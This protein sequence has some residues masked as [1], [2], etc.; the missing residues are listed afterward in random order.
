MKK[1]KVLRGMLITLLVLAILVS[2]GYLYTQF[3]GAILLP[4]YLPV[5]KI[6]FEKWQPLKTLF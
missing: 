2:A 1:K 5:F 4:G 3:H 6:I